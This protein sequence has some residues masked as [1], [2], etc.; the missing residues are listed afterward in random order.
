ME[1]IVTDV[2]YLYSRGTVQYLS[3]FL[4]LYN[5]EILEL[6]VSDR[7]DLELVIRP[8]QRLLSTKKS[9]LA[10]DA[11]I[12]RKSIHFYSLRALARATWNYTEYV[13]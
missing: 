7:N 3:V 6:E 4:D 8:L 12:P 11:I 5:N 2:T 9:D 1:K 13:S 10:P